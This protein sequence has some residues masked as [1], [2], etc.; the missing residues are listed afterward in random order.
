M[1][2]DLVDITHPVLIVAA[3]FD[4]QDFHGPFRMYRA[5]KEKNPANK[6]TL[7]VGPWLHGGWSRGDGDTLG[8][9]DFGS[10][11]AAHY[12]SDIEL[13]FF[14][15]YLK[16]KGRLNLAEAVVFETGGNQW[17]DLRPQWPPTGTRAAQPVS[18]GRRAAGVRALRPIDQTRRSTPTSAIP[19]SRCR[20]PRRSRR[21]KGIVF[22]VEDQRF[23]AGRPDVLVYETRA[24]DGGSDDRRP[25]RCSLNVATTGTD[26]DWVVKL[27]D[28]YPGN[29]PDPKPNPTTSDG[30][31]PDAARRRHP[32]R[33]V[34]QQHE[35]ARADGAEPADDADV[36]ARR[37]VPHVSQGPPRDGADSELVVPDVRSQSADLRRHLP[38]EG[39]T[40]RRRRTRSFDRR[41]GRRSS[42][43][44]C[45]TRD[46]GS[47]TVSDP[48]RILPDA[49]PFLP[50]HRNPALR[51]LRCFG[52]HSRKSLHFRANSVRT[53]F[54]GIPA[55]RV[56]FVSTSRASASTSC[57]GES[58]ACKSS[59]M[60]TT[61]KSSSGLFGMERAK[62]EWT[63]IRTRL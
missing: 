20:T 48:G 28:V 8:N 39:R 15:F 60:P 40:I 21:P 9:I 12:R 54:A 16:D 14:N 42:R 56:P 29:A 4:A 22:M 59:M 31:L 24:A 23:V 62:K 2:K 5:L 37:Q 38:R 18:A 17:H 50:F 41:R 51:I 10:K 58:I 52:A 7:V 33:E 26:G 45:S 1:P 11:T 44:Q 36:H 57:I 6:T 53:P 63:F 19:R 61:T 55:C 30:Q 49:S 3:W 43:C 32:A 13:P 25:D 27:I 47:D 46:K 34:P 35:H